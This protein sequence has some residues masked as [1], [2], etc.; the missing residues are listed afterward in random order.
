MEQL[1][2]VHGAPDAIRLDNGPEMTSETFTEWTKEKGNALL[3]IQPIKPNQ[4]AFVNRFNRSIRNE[5]LDANLFKSIA[6][7]HKTAKVWAMA[8]NKF[9]P[10]DYHSDKNPMEFIPR[11]FKT[12]ISCFE[13]ST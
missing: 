7:A 13:L 9:R 10:H 6:E 5:I 11:T 12:G 3:F 4:N 1:I 2:E 8:Y